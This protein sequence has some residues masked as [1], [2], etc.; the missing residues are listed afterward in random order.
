MAGKVD[1]YGNDV[2]LKVGGATD[3]VLNSLAL[4]VEGEA[5]VHMNVDTG[6]MRN[7]TYT[8]LVGGAEGT[9][10]AGSGSYTNRAGRSVQR[11]RAAMPAIPEGAAAVHMAADYSIFQELLNPCLYPAL[12]KAKKVAKGIIEQIGKEKL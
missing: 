8:I 7:A 11:N 1:W 12:E 3:E 10:S 5:K 9:T 2:L 4:W 6:F